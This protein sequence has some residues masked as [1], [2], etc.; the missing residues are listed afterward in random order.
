MSKGP[1]T[2]RI[3]Q[4]DTAEN[5]HILQVEQL[6]EQ[7]FHGQKETL[8]VPVD[9]RLS[10]L[11]SG[12]VITYYRAEEE[13]V[14]TETPHSEERVVLLF[15]R[16]SDGL[17]LPEKRCLWI[18]PGKP[19]MQLPDLP[20]I[21]QILLGLSSYYGKREDLVRAALDILA[22]SQDAEA[23]DALFSIR[24]DLLDKLL[25]MEY[26]V[27]SVQVADSLIAL[28]LPVPIWNTRAAAIC[29]RFCLWRCSTAKLRPRFMTLSLHTNANKA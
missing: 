9:E 6:T 16:S 14:I 3:N 17:G 26:A 27:V 1:F 28:A 21:V 12:D 10:S 25:G 7:F 5:F 2:A 23:I 24:P 19:L 20:R 8:K 13:Y 29:G 22:L 15:K 4:I 11:R 18:A